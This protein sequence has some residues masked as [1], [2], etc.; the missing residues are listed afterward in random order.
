MVTGWNG[1]S[2]VQLYATAPVSAHWQN[3]HFL[4]ISFLDIN[5]YAHY[6]RMRAQGQI[7]ALEQ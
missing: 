4:G 3:L 7:D 6:W 1:L 5:C 2:K